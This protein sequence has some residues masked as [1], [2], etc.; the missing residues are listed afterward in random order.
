MWSLDLGP[1]RLCAAMRC[2]TIPQSS[3]V[4]RSSVATH[5][6][7]AENMVI[8]SGLEDTDIG[9]VH[10]CDDAEKHWDTFRDIFWDIHFLDLSGCIV[11]QLHCQQVQYQ[12]SVV[13]SCTRLELGFDHLRIMQVERERERERISTEFKTMKTELAAVFETHCLEKRLSELKWALENTKIVEPAPGK[14]W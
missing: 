9:T 5:C 11:N 13:H 1:L 12:C 14:S 8:A 4:H 10:H 6:H 3:T 7:A 2:L